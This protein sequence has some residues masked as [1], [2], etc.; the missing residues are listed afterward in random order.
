MPNP[1]PKGVFDGNP[2]NYV[3]HDKDKYAKLVEEFK[4]CPGPMEKILLAQTYANNPEYHNVDVQVAMVV[5]DFGGPVDDQRPPWLPNSPAGA[6]LGADWRTR[7]AAA[8]AAAA[9]R[10]AAPKGSP[11]KRASLGKLLKRD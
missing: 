5:T 3:A 6:A 4:E 1:L 10:E 8:H 2:A 9:A 11:M 7:H